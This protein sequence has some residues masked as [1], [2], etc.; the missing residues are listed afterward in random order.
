M[1]WGKKGESDLDCSRKEIWGWG[2]VSL[3]CWA[4]STLSL[5]IPSR[6]GEGSPPVS[7]PWGFTGLVSFLLVAS[8]CSEGGSADLEGP[9]HS[10]DPRKDSNSFV[11]RY[12]STAVWYLGGWEKRWEEDDSGLTHSCPQQYSLWKKP[13]YWWHFLCLR[14]L[15]SG[16]FVL[17]FLTDLFT[18]ANSHL[19]FR[20]ILHKI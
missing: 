10:V 4:A 11:D 17:L 16:G 18:K 14:E 1:R 2:K 6:V 8:A 12:F 5:I 15:G 9:G 7:V 3:S 20:K 19:R 13:L